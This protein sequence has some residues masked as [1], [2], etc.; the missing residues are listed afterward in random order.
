MNL[1]VPSVNWPYPS[2]ICPV[3]IV[4]REREERRGREGEGGRGERKERKGGKGLR[5]GEEE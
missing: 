5:E 2:C 1:V 4:R 3:I